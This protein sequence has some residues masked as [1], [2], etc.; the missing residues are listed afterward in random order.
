MRESAV[1]RVFAKRVMDLGGRSFKLAPIHAGNPDR[2]VL[3]PGGVVRFVELKADG[4]TL[5][6]AQVLW[7]KRAAELGIFVHVVT[8]AE[9][10]RTWVP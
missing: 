9:E 5:H 4:E 7:H 6:A 1:E 8:G 3:L 10:A 2:V